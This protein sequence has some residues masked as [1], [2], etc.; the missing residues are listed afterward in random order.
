M[1]TQTLPA[2]QPPQ[3]PAQATP[4]P[5]AAYLAG[6]APGSRPTMRTALTRIA[7]IAAPGTPWDAVPWH[8]LRA[9][10][11]GAI[12]AHLAET[13]A[14]ATAN[15]MLAAL[16]GVLRAAWRLEL[17]PTEAY[18]R[19]IDVPPVTGKALP[20]AAGRALSAGELYALAAAAADG[21][22]LGTRDNALVAVAYAG[23]L[24][25]AEIAALD[26]GDVAERAG[27]LWLTVRS[28]KGRK[29]RTVPL[30]NGAADA[31]RSWIEWRGGAAGPLFLPLRKG[32]RAEWRRLHPQAIGAAMARLATAA[33]V[34]AFTP[35][36]LRR[37]FAGDLLDSGADIATVA[38]LM[39]H[40]NTATTAGYDRRG[41]RAKARAA[42]G[43][44]YP[45]KRTD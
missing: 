21:S 42:K 25:R 2:V 3:L 17:L 12:R 18:Q 38:A 20:Q 30:D 28:G 24:R 6:L 8:Q 44:H 16:R 14:P 43:L 32:G 4:N 22:P 23:G 27:A 10:H 31:L 45:H 29:D 34:T 11:V 15:R 41:D 1:P 19:A 35:H 40:A 13:Y 5:A 39:G 9:S 26:L 36:D 33:R 37:T 7:E